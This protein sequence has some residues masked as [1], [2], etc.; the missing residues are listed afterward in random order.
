MMDIVEDLENTIK[1][2]SQFNDDHTNSL[3]STLMEAKRT[4]I[5]YRRLIEDMEAAKEC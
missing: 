2:Y 3:I 5:G 4:I 1:V